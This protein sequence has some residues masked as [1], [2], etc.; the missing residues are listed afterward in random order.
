MLRVAIVGSRDYPDRLDVE[1]LVHQLVEAH[2][3]GVVIISG[4]A[5]GPDSWAVEVAKD[6]GLDTVVH[7]PDWSQGKGAW[8]DRDVAIVRD[9]D[10]VYAFWDGVSDGT[11]NTIHLARWAGCLAYVFTPA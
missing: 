1:Q 5:R 11:R 9:A 3:P 7:R 8:F 2:G 4:G 6:L 10:L